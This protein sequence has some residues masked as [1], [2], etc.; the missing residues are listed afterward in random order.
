MKKTAFYG[1]YDPSGSGL[2]T[3]FTDWDDAK[4]RIDGIKNR[5]GESARFKKF[6]FQSD[7]VY[8]SQHGVCSA[9]L[10][11]NLLTP[12]AAAANSIVIY[13]DGSA[14]PAAGVAGYGVYFG[15]PAFHH[16]N[17]AEPLMTPPFTNNRAEL[18]AIRRAID[19][20]SSDPEIFRRHLGLGVTAAAAVIITDSK[21]ARDCLGRWRA[22][23]VQSD[24]RNG[25]IQNQD[26]IKPLYICM[27]EFH[28]KTGL[29]LDIVWTKGHAGILGNE[30]ADALAEKG[31]R[32][33]VA[34]VP[35]QKE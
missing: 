21:Y 11:S 3:T 26:L 17:I 13:T 28:G 19:L 7:A 4:D 20:V 31:A 15:N 10:P 22:K 16:L 27:D 25:T 24:F 9:D 14:F 33:A 5:T 6:F 18:M 1:V 32:M 34:A 23:W 8:F 2:S 29:T 12:N 35:R 30:R